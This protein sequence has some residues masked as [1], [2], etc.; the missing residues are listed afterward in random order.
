MRHFLPSF[1][2]AVLLL[3]A[4][5]APAGAEGTGE[6]L[7]QRYDAFEVARRASVMEALALTPEQA[8]AFEPIYDE[9]RARNRRLVDRRLQQLRKYIDVWNRRSADARTVRDLTREMIA[10]DREHLSDLQ[11]QVERVAGVLPPGKALDYLLL[12]YQLDLRA[13]HAALELVPGY[14]ALPTVGGR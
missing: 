1:L 12:E 3:A 13:R 10:I 14:D 4:M 11:A 2:S 6:A 8:R 9:Y 5:A 7:Q